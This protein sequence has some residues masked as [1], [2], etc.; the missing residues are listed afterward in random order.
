MNPIKTIVSYFYE[1]RLTA[2][3]GRFEKQLKHELERHKAEIELLTARYDYELKGKDQHLEDTLKK[4]KVQEK[5]TYLRTL[6]T[7]EE[8]IATLRKQIND[9]REMRFGIDRKAS[10]LQTV[11]DSITSDLA[12]AT[13]DLMGVVKRV[14]NVMG[15]TEK[16]SNEYI[17]LDSRLKEIREIT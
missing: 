5:A 11:T 3:Q 2:L 17:K 15:K 1:Q 9:L 6:R 8:E 7:Y 10:N 13:K 16:Y 14:N 12:I 4:I